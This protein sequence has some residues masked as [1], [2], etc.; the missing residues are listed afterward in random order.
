MSKLAALLLLA[1]ASASA[2]A[3]RRVPGK[4]L[5]RKP[6]ISDRYISQADKIGQEVDVSKAASDIKDG[7]G[8]PLV[9]TPSTALNDKTYNRATELLGG[10]SVSARQVV[11][12][13]GRWKSRT[14]WND[15]GIG[16]KRLIDDFRNGDYYEEDL[17]KMKTDFSKPMRYYIA[18]RPQFMDFCERC[19]NSRGSNSGH[20]HSRTPRSNVSPS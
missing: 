8:K 3:A 5:S 17:P 6:D 13:L 18:R 11:N 2:F 14:E 10:D 4:R 9:P 16:Q 7:L 15:A 19:E 12:A 20:V 1:V